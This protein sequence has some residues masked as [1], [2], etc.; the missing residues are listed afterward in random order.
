MNENIKNYTKSSF[1]IINLFKTLIYKVRFLRDNPL[2]MDPAGIWVFTGCQG[3]GKTLTAV[4][5][6]YNL[7][8]LYPN[9]MIVSNL[10][11][12][13]ID[14]IPF[15]SYEDIY[16]LSNGIEGIIFLID[17]VHILWN[18]LESKDISFSEMAAFCQNRKDRRVIVG[19]S[20]VY[21]RIAKPI[22]E[23]LQA[24]VQCDCFFGLFQHNTIID[25]TKCLEDSNG[26]LNAEII[27][28]QYFFHSPEMYGRFDTYNKINKID[29]KRC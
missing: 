9:A 10:D 29:R 6:V 8:K 22:R 2:F 19:T 13:D 16:K 11:L 21:T 3:S 7:H 4:D 17:E 25:P 28:H 12:K 18:S 5:T 14:Y 1:N 15:E 27:G 20:Q 23:Q 24:I 26:H